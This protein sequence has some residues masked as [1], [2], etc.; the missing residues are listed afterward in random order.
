MVVFRSFSYFQLS[1][2]RAESKSHL[3]GARKVGPTEGSVEERDQIRSAKARVS[4][5]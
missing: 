5:E 2:D 4:I 3:G 1:S